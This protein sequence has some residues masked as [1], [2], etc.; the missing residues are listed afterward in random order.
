MFVVWVGEVL[1]VVSRVGII[2]SIDPGFVW[3]VSEHDSVF[4]IH[5]V[6]NIIFSN[7]VAFNI[8]FFDLEKIITRIFSF[9]NLFIAK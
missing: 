1:F 6:R 2:F 7:S 8:L 9:T 3:R 4:L 5:K